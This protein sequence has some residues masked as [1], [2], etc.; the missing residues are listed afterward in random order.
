MKNNTK[1]R[2]GL[3][4]DCLLKISTYNSGTQIQ[5]KI[6]VEIFFLY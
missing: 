6:K 3:K 4:F 5:I 2:E 1:V